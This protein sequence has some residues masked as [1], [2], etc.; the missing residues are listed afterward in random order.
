MPSSFL[1]YWSLSTNKK[2]NVKIFSPHQYIKVLQ[3][4]RRF[5][6][7]QYKWYRL[8]A[9][10]WFYCIDSIA[11]LICT[12][13]S[14]HDT[15]SATKDSG[16]DNGT[17]IITSILRHS[18]HYRIFHIDRFAVRINM[19]WL[20]CRYCCVLLMIIRCRHTNQYFRVCCVS[21]NFFEAAAQT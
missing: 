17:C 3:D 12:A 10:K 13:P 21:I 9:T 5:I 18:F 8:E 11:L 16:Q 19:M 1:Y 2:R 14:P 7:V 20:S 6:F 15:H 4:S